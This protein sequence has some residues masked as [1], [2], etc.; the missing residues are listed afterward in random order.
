MNECNTELQAIRDTVTLYTEGVHT[1]NIEMLKKAF[2][3]RAMMYGTSG[4]NVTM[5]EI[6]GLYDYIAANEPPTK[7]AEPHQCFISSIQ[8]A[9]N[10]ALVEVMEESLYGH[11]YTNYLQL[12]KIE[13]QW[14]IVC[15]TYNATASKP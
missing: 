2:H 7:T 14:V 4:K 11:D 10:A 5:V 8:Y 15:K 12:L 6:Q 3:P 9:G 13:E 1:G